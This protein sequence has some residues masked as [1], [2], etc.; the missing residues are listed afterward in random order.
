MLKQKPSVQVLPSTTELSSPRPK[1]IP[2]F[3]I[4]G[5]WQGLAGPH[6]M[7]IIVVLCSPVP[8]IHS[9]EY[10]Q[11]WWVLLRDWILTVRMLPPWSRSPP[12][13][14]CSEYDWV[15]RRVN[16][17]LGLSSLFFNIYV[18]VLLWP[19][20]SS[21]FFSPP[22]WVVLCDPPLYINAMKHPILNT[23]LEFVVIWTSCIII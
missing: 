2:S 23:F 7:F 5:S 22:F 18:P 11:K 6:S 19:C 10:Q 3:S 12:T 20:E 15:S 16:W 17:A 13:C 14:G 8:S 4:I 1:S 21:F 9:L